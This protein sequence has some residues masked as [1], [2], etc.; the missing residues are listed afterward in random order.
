MVRINILL[1]K[2]F[3]F[4]CLI[5][6]M[7]GIFLFAGLSSSAAAA[8]YTYYTV[9]AGDS[10]TAI[11]REYNTTPS[12]LAKDNGIKEQ[13]IIYVGQVLKVPLTDA[14]QDNEG[15]SPPTQNEEKP[16]YAPGNISLFIKDAD[17][18]DALS[19]L[20]I[21]MGYS[22]IYTG[23]PVNVSLKIE[24]VSPETA[25]DYLLKLV[26][27]TYL[28]DGD[29][30]LVGTKESLSEDFMSRLAVTTFKLKYVTSDIISAK[31]QELEINAKPFIMESNLSTI[32]VQGFPQEIAKVRQLINLL[33]VSENESYSSAG[34]SG[35]GLTAVRLKY[36][37]PSEF[38]SFLQSL[39]IN[40][41]L[42]ISDSSGIL[43]VY[44]SS[45]ERATVMDIKNKVDNQYMVLGSGITMKKLVLAGVSKE[46]ALS[47]IGQLD[48]KA[49][50]ITVDSLSRVIW[51]RGSRQD[52]DQAIDII[53]SIDADPYY[54][55][56]DG[57]FVNVPLRNIRADIARDKLLKMKLP[58]VDVYTFN[59]PSLSRT[60]LVYCNRDYIAKVQNMVNL[61]DSYSPAIILPIDVSAN[62]ESLRAR[63]D[64]LCKLLPSLN[65]SS[66]DV[67][68]NVSKDRGDSQYIL[69]I[70]ESPE[71]VKLV[72]EMLDRIDN[73]RQ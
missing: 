14:S 48:L 23:A 26:K 62:T 70:T 6:F 45:D 73:P 8:D 52:V 20:A 5:L 71:T 3:G 38:N 44:G 1:K 15:V 41:G 29:I 35:S 53:K 54:D 51:L 57:A 32:W 16:E 65:S 63:R 2:R 33:D 12:Q 64:L 4:A 69:Y 43:W 42:V 17:I 36:F 39:G 27:M 34:E 22:I 59:Y 31:I 9:K 49:Q 50:P 55:D 18:R 24:N 11:A 40:A 58:N 28:Q 56:M 30:L 46:N 60:I 21:N 25:M 47:V 7:A 68:A 61:L 72:Q 19:A 67:S 13:G 10:L 66:F 37:T